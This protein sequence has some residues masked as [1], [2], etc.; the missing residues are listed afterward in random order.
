[1]ELSFSFF[2]LSKIILLFG[3]IE[4]NDIATNKIIIK[5]KTSVRSYFLIKLLLLYNIN[6]LLELMDN[7]IFISSKRLLLFGKL[8]NDSWM[9]FLNDN[10]NIE[11]INKFIKYNKNNY[12]NKK[13]EWI[14]KTSRMVIYDNVF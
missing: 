10:H 3:G 7:S 6:S 5:Q 11:L 2:Q 9:K 1:M 8:I 12:D 4:F 14:S 13:N